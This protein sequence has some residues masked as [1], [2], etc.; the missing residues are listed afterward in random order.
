MNK[1]PSTNRKPPKPL[2]ERGRFMKNGGKH[3]KSIA[4]IGPAF[5]AKCKT[6]TLVID[7]RH[8]NGYLRRRRS[9]PN[10]KCK[11]PRFTTIELT[12][13]D[14]RQNKSALTAV[15]EKLQEGALQDLIGK[16]Q[17]INQ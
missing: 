15:M 3:H 12:A 7:T 4:G 5:C 1:G 8:A 17:G 9:C 14:A 10:S 13:P 11:A 6:H 16:L 2:N